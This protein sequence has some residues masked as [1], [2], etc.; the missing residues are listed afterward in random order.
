[1]SN[2]GHIPFCM[3]VGNEGKCTT[4]FT[5]VYHIYECIYMDV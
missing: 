1:M 4:S 5:H 3:H 2:E